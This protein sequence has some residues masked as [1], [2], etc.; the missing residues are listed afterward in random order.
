MKQ[1]KDL[2]IFDAHADTA[3][4]LLDDNPYMLSKTQSHLEK[5]KIKNGGLNAQIFALWV[6]PIYAPH[7]ALK[8]ALLL[9]HALE[10][11]I[12]TSNYGVKVTSIGEMDAALKIDKLAC[13]LSLEGGHIIENS[14]K[15]LEFFHML[16]VRCMTLTHTKNTDWADSSGDKPQW[17]GLT[18]FGRQIIAEMD[19][20]HMAID[21][22]HAT[23]KT[24]EDVLEVTGMPVMASHSSARAL[25][26]IPRN[27]PD[28]LIAEIAERDGF[29]GVNFYP[30]FLDKSIYEQVL[31]NQEKHWR[32]YENQIKG[33]EDDPDFC[34]AAEIQLLRKMVEGIGSVDL[35]V[36]IDHIVHIAEVGGVSCVGLGS[37]FDGIPTTPCGLTDVSCYPLLVE[38]LSQRG[39]TDAEIRSIM[40]LNLYNFLKHF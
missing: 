29:I 34:N 21:V 32:W 28:D 24:A 39:F 1:K 18:K 35:D 31:N 26:D 7:R 3:N 40:G 8:K 9:Y 23:D 33:N 11:Q 19:A 2:M 27:I 13:W 36:V 12:F 38:G 5:Q 22:S 20:L 17:D 25:C 14:I 30:G 15:I 16:G 37:D 4:V 10:T 6:N